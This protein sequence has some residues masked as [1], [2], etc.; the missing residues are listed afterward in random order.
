MDP[1]PNGSNPEW[2]ST[3][4]GTEPRM[5]STP[6]GTQPRVG[7]NPKWT[8]PRPGTQPR[9]GLNRDPGL[10]PFGWELNSEWDSIS[11]ISSQ[12]LKYGVQCVRW[13]FTSKEWTF[14]KRAARGWVPCP[15]TQPDWDLTP[16]WELNSEWVLNLDFP[17]NSSNIVYNNVSKRCT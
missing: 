14:K 2:D 3:P 6:T 16:D 13:R 15:G 8:Q 10:N 11:T 4:N 7:L 17:L 1:T 9:L 12:P 5:D